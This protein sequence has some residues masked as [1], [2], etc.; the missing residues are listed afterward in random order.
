[1]IS[2]FRGTLIATYAPPGRAPDEALEAP[3]VLGFTDATSKATALGGDAAV[4]A[5]MEVVAKTLQRSTGVRVYSIR[6]P[7]LDVCRIG[8]PLSESGWRGVGLSVRIV[9]LVAGSQ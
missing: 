5:N 4:C 3:L 2:S 1:M 9:W 6:A 8:R 7:T